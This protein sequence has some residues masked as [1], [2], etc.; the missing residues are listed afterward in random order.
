M[1]LSALPAD[2]YA[3]QLGMAVRLDQPRSGIKLA[4]GVWSAPLS[5]ADPTLRQTLLTLAARV[6]NPGL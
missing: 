5:T 2:V 4:P 6:D 1:Q 3:E